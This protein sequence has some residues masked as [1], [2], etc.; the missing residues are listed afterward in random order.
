MAQLL[1]RPPLHAFGDQVRQ[2]RARPPAAAGLQ[3]PPIAQALHARRDKARHEDLWLQIERTGLIQV[4][5]AQC[6]QG[7][8]P[9]LVDR[10]DSQAPGDA[11]AQQV[12]LRPG[13]DVTRPVG[14]VLHRV[15]EQDQLFVRVQGRRPEALHRVGGQGGGLGTDDQLLAALTADRA[16][17]VMHRHI[18]PPLPT[19]LSPLALADGL[20]AGLVQQVHPHQVFALAMRA[21]AR[22]PAR[23][24]AALTT[25]IS[26]LHLGHQSPLIPQMWIE[27]GQKGVRVPREEAGIDG[28][29]SRLDPA[30][31]R[32]LEG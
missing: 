20:T 19:L 32:R 16:D 21:L 8:V 11:G 27:P 7:L 12:A 2:V 30:V 1:H 4:A 6:R 14:G 31:V 26:L 25:E 3:F 28:L 18:P 29:Q 9:G 15:R 10:L 13:L 23:Q 22:G 5:A 24:M 17:V